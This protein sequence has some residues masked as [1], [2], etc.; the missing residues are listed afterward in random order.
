LTSA[1]GA[2]IDS[3]FDLSRAFGASKSLRPVTQT[4]GLGYFIT[5]RWRFEGA[6]RQ[7]IKA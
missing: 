2:K 7:A 1:E 6:F 4:V 3:A 5:R